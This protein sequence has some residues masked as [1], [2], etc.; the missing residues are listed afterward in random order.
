MTPVLVTGAAGFIGYHLSARLLAEGRTVVGLDNLSDY[1]S[2]DLKRARLAELQKHNAFSFA[3]IDLADGEALHAL[4]P[5]T[6]SSWSTT[7]PR[8]R[9]CATLWSIRRLT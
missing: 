8:K 6:A 9:A 3:E 5:S 4:M 7:W 2:V 1:Y